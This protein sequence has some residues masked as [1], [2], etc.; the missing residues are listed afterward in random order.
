MIEALTYDD[1]LL[2]PQ[3]SDIRSRKEI[4]ISPYPGLPGDLISPI[5]SS[6]MDT[7]TEVA[8]CLAMDEH[9]GYGILHRYNT[10]DEQAKMVRLIE[11]SIQY[12]DYNQPVIP[13]YGCAIGATGDYYERL[14]TLYVRGCRTFCIDI[15]HGHHVV[16][17]DALE[18]I[19]NHP[20]RKY[21]RVIA[22]NVATPEGAMD[23]YA[24]GADIVKVGIGGGSICS[25]RIETGHGVP[26]VEAVGKIHQARIDNDL[27]FKIIADGGIKSAGDIVKALALGANFVMLGSMLAGTDETPGIIHTSNSG[28]KIK[29][30]RGMA[31]PE[32]QLAWK[33]EVSSEEGIA[34]HIPA[35]GP[36]SGV[37]AHIDKGIRSGLSYSGARTIK[38]LQMTAQFIRQSNSSKVE[39]STHILNK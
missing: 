39:S 12:D 4:D 2:K 26:N 9:G 11:E 16:M 34:T 10:I 24:W 35:K 31:S 1:L 28:R 8:M 38:E 13:N 30:Y 32:S 22:G 7:V 25:T 18:A 15:A 3:Y 6:P 21:F 20:A 14:C 27:D 19:K 17:K 33:G 29:E 23:L 37:L 5:I 36:V